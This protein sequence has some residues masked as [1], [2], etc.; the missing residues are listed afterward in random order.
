MKKGLKVFIIIL[1]S[2]F[3]LIFLIAGGI[4]F[5]FRNEISVYS[6]IKQLKPANR[7]ALQGGEYEITY[8]GNYLVK[9][10]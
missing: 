8:K 10:L 5:V 3:G 2:L 9:P 1:T 4:A 6:S 7:D